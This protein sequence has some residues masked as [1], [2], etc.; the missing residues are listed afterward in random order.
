[1]EYKIAG[2]N[3]QQAEDSVGDGIFALLHPARRVGLASVDNQHI[4]AIDNQ[5]HKYKSGDHDDI[6]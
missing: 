5:I 6:R 3:K 1:M 4:S 2:D